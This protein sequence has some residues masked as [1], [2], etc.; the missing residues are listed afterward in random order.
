MWVV[1][2]VARETRVKKSDRQTSL[3][4]MQILRKYFSLMYP[5]R[6]LSP[7]NDCCRVDVAIGYAL[8]I[9]LVNL[10]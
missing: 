7:K 5:E 1:G 4:L 8:E 9:H 2:E 10:G 6:S 3:T